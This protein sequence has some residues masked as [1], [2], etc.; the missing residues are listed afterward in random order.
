LRRKLSP[1]G[2]KGDA[3][4]GASRY[5]NRERRLTVRLGADS[6]CGRQKWRAITYS[7]EH[8]AGPQCMKSDVFTASQMAQA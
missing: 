4:V 3:P 6:E 1:A 8:S 5:A 7:A 2:T